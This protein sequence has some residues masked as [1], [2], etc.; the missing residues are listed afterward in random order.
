M[1]APDSTQVHLG[2]VRQYAD[3]IS[4]D[5]LRETRRTRNSPDHFVVAIFHKSDVFT[6]EMLAQLSEGWS[7]ITV[8][9]APRKELCFSIGSYQREGVSVYADVAARLAT[10]PPPGRFYVAVFALDHVTT[11][12]LPA[13]D[14]L[15]A[16]SA[17]AH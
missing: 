13:P 4:R 8:A 17:P 10:P 11:M 14:P 9:V 6:R 3:E 5:L 12:T 1:N 7:E 15:I 16:A 2:M